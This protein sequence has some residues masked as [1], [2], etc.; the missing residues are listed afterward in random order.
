MNLSDALEIVCVRKPLHCERYRQLCADGNPDVWQRD[1]YRDSLISEAGA[2]PESPPA[3]PPV[4]R[5]LLKAVTAA[6]TGQTIMATTEERERRQAI[7]D[8]CPEWDVQQRRCKKCGCNGNLKLALA[9][10]SCPIGKWLAV[11]EN[12]A[13]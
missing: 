1:R 2:P 7:C 5:Q 13:G 12:P 9:T 8:V 4:G 3:Y 6:V 11:I 10:E